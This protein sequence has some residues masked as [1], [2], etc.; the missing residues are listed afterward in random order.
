MAPK[1]PPLLF[2]FLS[3][4]VVSVPSE[5]SSLPRRG[6]IVGGWRPIDNPKDPE[7]VKIAKFAVTEHNKQANATLSFVTVV[8]GESQVVAGMNYRLVISAKDGGAADPKNY[9]AL[10]WYKPWQKFIQLLS[11]EEI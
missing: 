6:T 8:K 3:I 11:F 2:V 5:A 4:L 10:V 1:S 9:R 7:V